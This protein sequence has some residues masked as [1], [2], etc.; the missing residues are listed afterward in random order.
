MKNVLA[1]AVPKHQRKFLVINEL[2]D[3]NDDLPGPDELDLQVAFT[4]PRIANKKKSF[5]N[6]EELSDYIMVRLAVARE[7][8]MKKYQETWA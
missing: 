4:R 2:T 8:A 6:D 7:K 1:L 5:D 3:D